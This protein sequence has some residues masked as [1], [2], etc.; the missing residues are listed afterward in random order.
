MRATLAAEFASLGGEEKTV[1]LGTQ[2]V[3]EMDGK[4]V[5]MPLGKALSITKRPDAGLRVLLCG[6]LDTVYSVGH[7]FQRCVRLD[8]NRLQGPGVT[9]AKGGLVV[10]LLALEALERGPWAESLGWEVLI[11]PDEEIGSPGSAKLL[12]AAAHRNRLG[13]VF[14]PALPDGGLVGQRKGTGNFTVVVRGRAAHAG[15]DPDAGRNAINALARYIVELNDLHGHD[16]GITVNVGTIRGGGPVNV[17]PDLAVCRMNVRVKEPEEQRRFEANLA[18]LSGSINA[19]DGISLELSGGFTRP[20]KLLDAETCQ[21]L[22][23]VA[24]CGRDLGLS[25]SWRVSGGACDGNNLAAE[26]LPTVDSMG[27]RGGNLHSSE[28]YMFIDSITERAQLTAL[29]LM[30]LASG[31]LKV[32]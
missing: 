16:Q 8:E 12:V 13:L 30:K 10:M 1:E 23:H 14:E 2:Q 28:E 7:P 22:D 19:L 17:V 5:N 9:D 32:E 11:N 31:E 6:H 29:L 21:M 15:R 26:G 3:V 18:R 25:I 20:P 24:E 27:V 4:L